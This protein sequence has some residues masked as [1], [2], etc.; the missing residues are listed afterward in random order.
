MA[1]KTTGANAKNTK[2][3][4][5]N[6][7]EAPVETRADAIGFP[8]AMPVNLSRKI[9][10]KP[11]G[12]ILAA[13]VCDLLDEEIKNQSKRIK[14]LSKW[15][16]QY[17]GVKKPR[18]YPH[19]KAANTAIPKSRSNTD[20]ILVR[21]I[22]AVWGQIKLWVIKGLTPQFVDKAI[23][24]E[25]ALD[26]WQKSIVHLR[27]K[28]YSPLMQMVKTGTGLG[29]LE[30]VSKKRTVY[31]Y[32]SPIEAAT[33]KEE[34][35]LVDLG[36]GQKGIK[37]ITSIYEGPD[38]FP[39]DRA[40]WVISSDSTDVQKALLCGFRFY[41]RKPEIELRVKQ[42]KFYQSILDDLGSPDE[43]DDN[44]KE[45]AESQG[46]DITSE[47]K[48]PYEFWSLYYKRDVD[49][50]GEEDDI[51][52][53]VYPAKKKIA[54]CVYNPLFMGFRP[55]IDFVFFPQQYS[56]DGEGICEI[57]EKLQEELDTIHNQR[58]DRMHQINAPIRLIERGRGIEGENLEPGRN[59]YI[60]GGVPEDVIYEL[61]Q[62]DVYPSTFNEEGILTH[63]MDQAT[64][65]TPESQGLTESE[66]PVAR[67]TLARIQE[68][69]K[70]Y[71]F[72]IDNVLGRFSKLGQ[73]ALEMFA[74]YSPQMTYFQA[75]AKG[76]LEKRTLEFPFELLRD[77]IHVE[78]AASSEMLNASLR[79]EI[80]MTLLKM[81]R[82][83]TTEIG[84]MLT[85]L[86]NQA[87]HPAVK[88]YMVKLMETRDKMMHRVLADFGVRDIEGIL[89]E[90]D[91]DLMI[92][93]ALAGPP[94]APP[95]SQKRPTGPGGSSKPPGAVTR[96]GQSGPMAPGGPPPGGMVQ[97]P[98]GP[99]AAMKARQPMGPRGPMG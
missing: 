30:Y 83:H 87:I 9:D 89:A 96:P 36:N 1:R 54:S 16:K 74:Q 66:R 34:D 93:K 59:Y 6:T 23:D 82:E 25:N 45:R 53:T 65:I 88:T 97:G 77:G 79:Q 64:G 94:V 7:L 39:I 67:D 61:H 20:V 24:I 35:G 46:I 17:K 92:L 60:D 27:E 90:T 15:E 49:D 76:V 91:K 19:P 21:I 84:G 26:W 3:E 8:G 4:K 33:L 86:T 40:D 95:P 72:G 47:S 51:L 55:F 58:L 78:L 81:L 57:L 85:A 73:M 68:A 48:E 12:D 29:M 98:S 13:E 18:S 75:G 56:F 32:A 37:T 70:K 71:K 69:N 52:I 14:L 2:S 41:L 43:Y 11:L 63:Y 44:K 99:S 10:G 62:S 31:R 22:D 28:M 50:D 42:G 38:F 5:E 80:D